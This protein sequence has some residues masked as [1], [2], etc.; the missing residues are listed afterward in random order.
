MWVSGRTESVG[1]L[2]PSLRRCNPDQ[3]QR[4]TA[5]AHALAVSQPPAG[6]PLGMVHTVAARS[7]CQCHA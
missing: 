7:A 2:I 3:V 1:A 6:A 4:V 5:P